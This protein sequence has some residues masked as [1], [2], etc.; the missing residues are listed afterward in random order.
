MLKSPENLSKVQT[1]LPL[2]RRKW[3][4]LGKIT[5]E[6]SHNPTEKYVLEK[7][8]SQVHKTKDQDST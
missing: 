7:K 4:K 1:L 3:Q 5:N 2:K 8:I 6:M